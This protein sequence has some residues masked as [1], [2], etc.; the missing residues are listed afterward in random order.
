MWTRYRVCGGRKT[1]AVHRD[2][3]LYFTSIL[4]S[5]S[6]KM[7]LSNRLRRKGALDLANTC[8]RVG[9][10]LGLCQ[11]A[12]HGALTTGQGFVSPE[13]L[14]PTTY[15]SQPTS[16]HLLPLSPPLLNLC[17]FWLSELVPVLFLPAGDDCPQTPEFAHLSRFIKMGIEFGLSF[18]ISPTI[19]SVLGSILRCGLALSP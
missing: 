3:G 10:G 8:V 12:P 16:C 7:S 9:A 2:L 6:N 15:P 13:F 11:R 4:Y 18:R 19:P 17:V 5:L 14:F 1:K